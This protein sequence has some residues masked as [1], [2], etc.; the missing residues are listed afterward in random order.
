MHMK[1][2][3]ISIEK[4]YIPLRKALHSRYH[5]AFVY[6]FKYISH[7]THSINLVECRLEADLEPYTAI[8]LFEGWIKEL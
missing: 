1:M 6:P 8:H 7:P 2:R 3:Y 5:Q 4:R